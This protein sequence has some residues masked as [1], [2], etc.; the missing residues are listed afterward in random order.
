MNVGDLLAQ[1]ALDDQ[2]YAF[3]GDYLKNLLAVART[4]DAELA[5]ILLNQM[6]NDYMESGTSP[7]P[8]VYAFTIV[9]N[10]WS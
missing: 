4:G 8:D 6:Y 1:P 9:L 7:K 3:K 10:A 5:E 2:D